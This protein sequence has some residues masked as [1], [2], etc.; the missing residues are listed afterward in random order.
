MSCWLAQVVRAVPRNWLLWF[1]ERLVGRLGWHALGGMTVAGGTP[2][3]GDANPIK[4]RVELWTALGRILRIGVFRS[5]TRSGKAER[6]GAFV[7]ETRSR[8]DK[9]GGCEKR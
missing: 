4:A 1:V 3:F 2:V 9:D 7:G 6:A 8:K 5:E